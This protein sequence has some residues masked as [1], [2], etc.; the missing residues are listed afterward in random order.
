[1]LPPVFAL[2]S[3]FFPKDRI[4][5]SSSSIRMKASFVYLPPLTLCSN[6]MQFVHDFRVPS[7]EKLQLRSPRVNLPLSGRTPPSFRPC[8]A[9]GSASHRFQNEKCFINRFVVP[10]GQAS[11][12]SLTI[13]KSVGFTR[14]NWRQTTITDRIENL[15]VVINHKQLLNFAIPLPFGCF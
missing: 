3:V 2:I 13:N 12:C 9:C 11:G 6:E 4:A 1:M 5:Y 8:C 15:G 10:P 14:K 7:N